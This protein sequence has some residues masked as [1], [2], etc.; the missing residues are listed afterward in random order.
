M[1]WRGRFEELV[2]IVYLGNDKPSDDPRNDQRFELRRLEDSKEIRGRTRD[3]EE[4]QCAD[5]HCY[6][7]FTRMMK[8]ETEKG[9]GVLGASVIVRY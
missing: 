2:N 1:P 8:E 5:R 9:V 7:K 3:R 6:R 4:M